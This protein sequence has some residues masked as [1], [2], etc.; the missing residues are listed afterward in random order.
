L[1][2]RLLLDTHI[3]LWLTAGDAQLNAR[4]KET[5]EGADM[6]FISSASIWEIAIKVRLGKLAADPEQLISEIWNNGFEE[7]P[8]LS[9]HAKEVAKLPRHH[10]DPFDLLLVAQ[11]RTEPLHLL[12]A[13]RELAEYSELVIVI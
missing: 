6:V 2:V 9:R 7:L 12:T 1:I 4:A 5:I 8:V 10:G 11:A 13:D 3:F